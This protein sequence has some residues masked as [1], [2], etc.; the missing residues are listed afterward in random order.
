[1]RRPSVDS[2][3]S[4]RCLVLSSAYWYRLRLSWAVPTTHYVYPQATARIEFPRQTFCP[5]T[6]L[7]RLTL[8]GRAAPSGAPSFPFVASELKK[9]ILRFVARL[10]L[11]VLAVLRS[12]AAV[13][14]IPCRGFTTLLSRQTPQTTLLVVILLLTTETIYRC[15]ETITGA[16]LS[17]P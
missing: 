2:S 10:A 13:A 15:T 17:S 3:T 14:K 11:C 16:R 1:M 4:M 12:T 8:C 5:Q 9:V 7:S 6:T